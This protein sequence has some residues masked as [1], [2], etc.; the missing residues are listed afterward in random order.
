MYPGNMV[1]PARWVLLSK[2]LFVVTVFYMPAVLRGA[3]GR[4]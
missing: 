3:L 1:R 4:Q 2:L